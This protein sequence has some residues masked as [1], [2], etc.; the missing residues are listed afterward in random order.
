MTSRS[1]IRACAFTLA[2]AATLPAD[3][4]FLLKEGQ[5][6]AGAPEAV[7]EVPKEGDSTAPLQQL[8]EVKVEGDLDP[9]TEGDRKRRAQIKALP[10]LGTEEERELNRLEKLREWYD[11]LPKDANNLTADQKEFLEEQKEF[12]AKP[13]ARPGVPT[14]VERRNPAD[15]RDPIKAV[16][17]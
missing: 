1:R 7:P 14:A 5:G 2:L 4:Q 12:D 8:P 17:P 10:G 9:L 11:T 3:A 16:S 13:V 15:Y 6:L